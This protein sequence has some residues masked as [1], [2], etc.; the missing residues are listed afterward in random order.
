MK[1]WVLK[2][3]T[4]IK[5]EFTSKVPHTE[6]DLSFWQDQLFYCFLFYCFPV[7]MI[8][9][10]PG[11][12]MAIKD[13]YS[14]IAIVDL[15]CLFGL[16][17]VT[18]ISRVTLRKRKLAIIC[19]FY[20]LAIFLINS[21]GYIGPGIFYLFGIT[22]LIAL[23]LPVNYACWSILANFLILAIFACI[24]ELKLFNS[25]L[26]QEY[27]IG[28]WIAFGSNLIF[29][30]IV[31]VALIHQ[32]FKRLQLTINNKTLLH[33]RY[34]NIFDSN[35]L[36]MWL[37]DAETLKFLDVNAAAVR[38]YGYTRN[39]FLLM[40]IADIRSISDV[41]EVK[42]IVKANCISGQYYTGNFQH[43][44]KNGDRIDVKIES[45][46]MEFDNRPA[47]LVVAT[48]ITDQLKSVRD[49]LSAQLKVIDSESN[50]RAIFE[51]AVEGFVLLDRKGDIKT[52]NS[53]AKAY[54]KFNKILAE[55]ENGKS[56]FEFVEQ[57]RYEY[58]RELLD[59][60]YVGE[61]I[62]YDRKYRASDRSAFWI[63]YTITPVYEQGVVNGCCITGRDITS[64]RIYLQ[65]I[66]EQNRTLREISWMQSHVVRA[67]VARIIGLSAILHNDPD[68]KDIKVIANYLNQSAEELDEVIKNITEKISPEPHG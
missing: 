53:K 44:K 33:E 1:D 15:S 8:A 6:E 68:D 37:F 65:K 36:P 39:E 25:A 55:F 31:F 51:N 50:L 46:L 45:N 49:I 52:F 12:F 11:V 18:F 35:P 32:I 19:I 20:V 34:K 29:L 43:I 26:N 42:D 54:I 16:I 9:V 14:I 58:F 47:R 67:P 41:S 66:E 40:T 63:H 57:S 62:E 21:L 13:G 24:I 7:S 23:I 10:I 27:T 5:G 59:K 30:S 48:D 4:L 2:Y 60:A 3:Q 28:A 61:V 38:H 22:I 17:L 56:I 64:G